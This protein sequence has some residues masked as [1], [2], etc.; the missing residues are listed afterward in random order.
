ML[1]LCITFKKGSQ[2]EIVWYSIFF[3]CNEIIYI[4]LQCEG[5]FGVAFESSNLKKLNQLS[6]DQYTFLSVPSIADTE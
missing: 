3:Y 1:D 6:L 5:P 2:T 4:K